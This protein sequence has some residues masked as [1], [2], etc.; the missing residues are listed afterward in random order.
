MEKIFLGKVAMVTG[1]SFGIGQAAAIAFAD[2]GAKVVI[3]DYVDDQTTLQTIKKAGGEAIFVKCDIAQESDVKKLIDTT[4]STYGKL[5]FAFNNAG[6]EGG[7]APTHESTNENWDRV[8]NTNLRGVWHCM[9]YELQQMLKAGG[10]VII[11]NASIAGL[12]GFANVPAYV[13]SKHGVLGLTKT[14]ALEYAK[15]KI[16]CNAIC[17]GVI[18]TP[19]IDRATGHNKEVEKQYADQEPVGRLGDPAEVAS[20]VLWLCSEGASFVTGVSLPVD[21]GWTAR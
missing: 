20:A 10:G 6:I 4:V 5:D 13:A 18:K 21:G 15:Q 17:P 12:V 16:R 3:A 14:V 9:K 19:M 1:G 8:I 11:N 2:A 7:S